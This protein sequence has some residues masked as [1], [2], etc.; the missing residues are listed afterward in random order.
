MCGMNAIEVRAGRPEDAA[1][2]EE[3]LLTLMGGSDV[4]G[5]GELIDATVLPALIAWIDGEAVGHLTYR[6]DPGDGWE[7]VTLGATR[8]GRGVGGALMDALL[9]AARRAG[10]SRVWL[11]TTNDNTNALRFYQRRGF[12]L[13]RLDRDA[14]TRSRRDLKPAIATHSD[15]IPIRHELELEWIP[16]DRV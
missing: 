3:S 15:G 11:I 13:V 5:H 8:P 2:V 10:V 7:V 1:Y 9:E 12:D 6:A 4:A 16:G 14:V